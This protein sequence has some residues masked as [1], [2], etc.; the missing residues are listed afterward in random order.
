M[1]NA[2]YWR[3]RAEAV[4][5]QAH[6][7]AAAFLETATEEFDK[8]SVRLQREIADWYRRFAD[9][10]GITLV[11][12]KRLLNT[13]ELKEFRWKVEDYINAARSIDPDSLDKALL[14]QLENASARVHISRLE[15]LQMQLQAESELLYGNQIDKLTQHLTSTYED[16][17]YRTAFTIQQGMEIGWSLAKLNE[18]AIRKALSEPWTADNNTFRDK[19]WTQK[20]Q[21]S[22]ALRTQ[23]TQGIIRGDN[24]M[25]MAD[26]IAKQ[27]NVS[28]NKA[29]RLCYTESAHISAL[30]QRDCYKELEVERFEIVETLD[31]LTCPT[32][33]SLDG[34]VLPMSR[35]EV[36]VTVPPFHPNC[37]GCT[38]PHFDDLG[39]ERAA[40]DENGNTYYVPGDMTYEKW[41][42]A[43]VYEENSFTT[44]KKN[45]IIKKQGGDNLSMWID[46]FTPCLE[47]CETGQIL[48]TVYSLA[49]KKELKYLKGW[50]FNWTAKDLSDCKIYKIT[51]AGQEEIQGLIALTSQPSETAVYVNLA[52]SAPHNLGSDKKYHGVG[53]HLFAIAA[54]ESIKMG[55]GGFFYMDAKNMELV[56]HYRKTLGALWIGMPHPYRMLVDEESAQKLLEIYNFKED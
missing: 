38:C 53:G 3:K 33:G 50:N 9:N 15:A 39:G 21:L 35:Y 14:K 17:Y 7:S 19:C 56:E 49:T 6:Q 24:P 47:D 54:N 10:N 34:K 51:L 26:V 44:R 23:L 13:K 29:A 18:N 41:K 1:K 5:E 55:F 40:R 11:E 30:S 27:F 45:G 48:D 42:E 43:V 36:G 46:K 52:E 37:R 31:S 2:D 28:K 12:A 32:C 25:Q 8:A 22:E 4:E 16:G 20:K